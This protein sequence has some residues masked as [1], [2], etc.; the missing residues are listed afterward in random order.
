[1][2]S[3]RVIDALTRYLKVHGPKILSNVGDQE[4]VR[5]ELRALFRYYERE[6]REDRLMNH[7]EGFEWRGC[8]VEGD[9]LL[10]PVSLIREVLG[11]E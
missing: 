10:V 2:G 9:Y 3:Q 11:V 7:I 6:S 5:I 1:M 8:R 4:I